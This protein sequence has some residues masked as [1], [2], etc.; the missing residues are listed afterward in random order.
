[1][2]WTRAVTPHPTRAAAATATGKPRAVDHGGQG[3]QHEGGLDGPLQPAAT[4]GGW[5]CRRPWP[6]PC[7]RPGRRGRSRSAAVGWAAAGGAEDGDGQRQTNQV[8][9]ADRATSRRADHRRP[10]TAKRTRMAMR[11]AEVAHQSVVTSQRSPSGGED[12][13]VAMVCS[14]WESAWV[15][16]QQTRTPMAARPTRTASVPRR[17]RRPSPT[18][19]KTMARQGRGEPIERAPPRAGQ[20]NGPALDGPV[21]VS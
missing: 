12:R 16:S 2:R 21:H 8:A 6:P 15:T 1:M 4:P 10:R 3:Q 17:R 19:A 13:V 11:P 18:G 9:T 14:A 7:A 5:R 20:R